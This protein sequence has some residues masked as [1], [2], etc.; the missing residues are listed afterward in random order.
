MT[1]EEMLEFAKAMYPTGTKFIPA[2]IGIDS[3]TNTKEYI[4]TATSDDHYFRLDGAELRA[5]AVSSWAPVLWWKHNNKWA[6]IVDDKGQIIP[7]TKIPSLYP[8]FN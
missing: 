6:S 4:A 1:N 3:H 5:H 7:V 8:I 2:H